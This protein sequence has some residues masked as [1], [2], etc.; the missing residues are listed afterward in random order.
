M[1]PLGTDRFRFAQSDV[2]RFG[3]GRSEFGQS[4]WEA[5]QRVDTGRLG[6]FNALGASTN[7][8]TDFKFSASL[9]DLRARAQAAEDAD[10][11]QK[12]E[13]SGL[14]YR[15]L[16]YSRPANVVKPGLDVW[17]E[18]QLSFYEDGTGGL[19]RD[20]RFGIVYV[21]ADLPLSTRVLFG[22]LAQ[23]DWTTEKI[24]DPALSGEIGGDGW[25]AGPYVGVKL[26]PNLLFDARIA[27]GTSKN[28]VTLT[29]AL[30]GTRTGS[31]DTTRWLATSTLTGNYN[32]GPWRLSPQA[33]LE[34]GNEKNDGFTNSLGQSVSG[35]GISIG[36]LTLGSEI[37]YRIRLSDGS[38][39]EPHVGITGIWNFHSDDLIINGVLVT[40]NAT[41]AKLEGGIIFKSVAGPSVRAAVSY[42]GIG[43][44]EL[45][46]LSGK[47]WLN[48][49]FH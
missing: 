12:L 23:F 39:V 31:F 24:K 3:V 49:P 11:Q 5:N 48:L 10:M 34:Y 25:M 28:N 45:S 8:A 13:A 41:R 42:D 6:A 22:V 46:A 18:G 27:W 2:G 37:G 4:D 16:P 19:T 9:S 33:G 44:S 17:T 38:L 43:S 21:G 35:N 32:Y 26:A 47:L 20:G 15:N 7:F 30:V 29:D 14:G 40:P 1:G 36:R